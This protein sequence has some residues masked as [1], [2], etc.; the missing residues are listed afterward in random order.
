MENKSSCSIGLILDCANGAVARL[1]ICE[2]YL[3]TNTILAF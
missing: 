1:I 3:V 2:E